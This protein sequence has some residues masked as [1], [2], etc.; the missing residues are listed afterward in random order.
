MRNHGDIIRKKMKCISGYYDYDENNNYK[1]FPII[2]IT[3][4]YNYCKK[5]VIGDSDSGNK[6]T[7]KERLK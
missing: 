2:H 3:D 4:D 1:Y 5:S 6:A 7:N